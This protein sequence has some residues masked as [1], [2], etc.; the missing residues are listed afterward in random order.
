MTNGSTAARAS[1]WLPPAAYMVLIFYFSAQPYPLPM[2]TEN[3]WDK[4]LHFVGYG[5]LAFLFCR[6]FAGERVAFHAALLYAFLSASAYGASD[7]WH[8]SFTPGRFATA[9]DWVADTIGAGLGL[10]VFWI[11]D[12]ALSAGRPS[13]A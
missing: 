2:L 9:A 12:R 4:W 11:W 5:G 1:L 8:Q 6:A 3:F 13:T 7:E 10:I